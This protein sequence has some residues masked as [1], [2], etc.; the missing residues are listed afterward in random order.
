MRLIGQEGM[1]VIEEYEELDGEQEFHEEE[2]DAGLRPA[3][4]D[5]SKQPED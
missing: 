4:G 2:R 3:V 5:E 1:P